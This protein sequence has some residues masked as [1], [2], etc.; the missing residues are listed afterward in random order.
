MLHVGTTG[1]GGSGK[2]NGVP[3]SFPLLPEALNSAGYVSSW[4]GKWCGRRH[5]PRG[6][7]AS[8]LRPGRGPALQLP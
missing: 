6:V 8:C 1:G 3:L 2:T 4:L 7:H 5:R